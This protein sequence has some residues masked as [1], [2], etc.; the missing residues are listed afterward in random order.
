MH[1]QA[2]RSGRNVAIILCQHPLYMF[3]SSRFTDNGFAANSI[4]VL[5]V[6]LEKAATISSASTGLAK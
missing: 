3:H 4:S 2:A 6:C 1:I 5:P